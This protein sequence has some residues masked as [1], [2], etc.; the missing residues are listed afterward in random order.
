LSDSLES[1]SHEGKYATE[2]KLSFNTVRMLAGVF[3]K[4]IQICNT[5]PEI[6]NCLIE[7]LR[8][9]DVLREVHLFVSGGSL[10]GLNAIEL[11]A[12]LLSVNFK[13]TD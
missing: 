9:S 5:L 2:V 12:P 11:K 7:D 8:R 4:P 3:L 13:R 6:L 1:V 10:V